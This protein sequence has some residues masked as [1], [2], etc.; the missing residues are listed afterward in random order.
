M[1]SNS[2]GDLSRGVV[3]L[4]SA[5]AGKIEGRIRLQ[6]SVY[7]LK[8]LGVLDF[9]GPPFRYHHYGPYS[10]P[11]SYVLHSSVISGLLQEIEQE[12]GEELV[13]Y[14]YVLT[15]AGRR[16][17]ESAQR[18][19]DP[20]VARAAPLL[21]AAHYRTLEL[22]ATL[23]FIERDERISNREESMRRAL[24]LKPACADHRSDARNLLE[25]LGL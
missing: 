7:L 17:L 10:E 12:R 1:N 15:D 13:R 22:A 23:L 5:M 21:Q 19:L 16:W 2:S 4:V 14:S 11:L 8:Q 9:Q 18:E 25:Q 20:V 24:E 6:K 3:A